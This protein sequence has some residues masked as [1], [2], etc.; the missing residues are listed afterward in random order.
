MGYYISFFPRNDKS[1]RCLD[2]P[3]LALGVMGSAPDRLIIYIDKDLIEHKALSLL[4]NFGH[5]CGY[6][7]TVVSA[8]TGYRIGDEQEISLVEKD[9]VTSLTIASNEIYDISV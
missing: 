7:N 6:V 2:L 9:G 1:I 3:I 8:N 5:V 4:R